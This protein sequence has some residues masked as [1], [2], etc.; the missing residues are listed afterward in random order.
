LRSQS[1]PAI[2]HFRCLLSRTAP[3]PSS[4]TK[5]HAFS[6][7][8]LG[9]RMNAYAHVNTF[10]KWLLVATHSQHVSC[11]VSDIRTYNNANHVVEKKVKESSKGLKRKKRGIPSYYQ[12]GSASD[13]TFQVILSSLL[14]VRYGKLVGERS[15]NLRSSRV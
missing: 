1:Y 10:S 14:D 13:T 12:E 7:R 11:S 2:L 15:G 5:P 9:Q 8:N 3:P 6:Q 4:G